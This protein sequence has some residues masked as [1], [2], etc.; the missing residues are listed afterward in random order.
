[1]LCIRSIEVI[2]A[3]ASEKAVIKKLSVTVNELLHIKSKPASPAD[4]PS[5]EWKMVMNNPAA[6]VTN[7]PSVSNRIDN[8][9]LDAT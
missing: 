2:A 5:C 1:M 9:R 7:A 3:S 4:N 6:N 8:Q